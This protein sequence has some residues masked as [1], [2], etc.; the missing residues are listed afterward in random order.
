M[1]RG[2]D[3]FVEAGA[4]NQDVASVAAVLCSRVLDAAAHEREAAPAVQ[5]RGDA[6]QTRSMSASTVSLKKCNIRDAVAKNE[7]N[8]TRSESQNKEQA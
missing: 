2:A 1:S 5:E 8:E 7:V 4:A 3:V 6:V